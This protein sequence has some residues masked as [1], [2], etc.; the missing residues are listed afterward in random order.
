MSG[1]GAARKLFRGV[2]RMA[3]WN[4]F[5]AL[6]LQDGSNLDFEPSPLDLAVSLHENMAASKFW[7]R[8]DLHPECLLFRCGFPGSI[9][10]CR[11]PS[12]VHQ[13]ASSPEPEMDGVAS[14]CF[15]QAV[16]LEYI[17]SCGSS[18]I[19]HIRRKM[20]FSQP[21]LIGQILL[22]AQRS[23]FLSSA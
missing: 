7:K 5:Q 23:S 3:C 6:V 9:L 17:P 14:N 21:Q 16:L 1:S 2:P 13:R 10:S 8:L 22:S 15:W 4:D 12:R 18:R 19:P 20:R 11:I